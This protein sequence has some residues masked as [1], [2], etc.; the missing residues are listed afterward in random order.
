MSPADI[1]LILPNKAKNIM[2]NDIV[3]NSNLTKQAR[4][5]TNDI[6]TIFQFELG[7]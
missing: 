6:S 3:E 5:A 4:Y 7:S 1:L 2:Y